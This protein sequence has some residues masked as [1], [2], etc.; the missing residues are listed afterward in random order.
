MITPTVDKNSP[1]MDLQTIGMNVSE[2]H[3]QIGGN[4]LLGQHSIV[5]LLA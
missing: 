2:V 4:W 5:I 1:W 3:Q